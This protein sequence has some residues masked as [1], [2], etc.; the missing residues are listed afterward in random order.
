MRQEHLSASL[1]FSE[2]G[3][4]GRFFDGPD[5]LG[6]LPDFVDDGAWLRVA[7]GLAV[8]RKGCSSVG[9]S[10]RTGKGERPSG[11]AASHKS[12]DGKELRG[13]HPLTS[14][15]HWTTNERPWDDGI[16]VGEAILTGLSK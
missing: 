2:V 4:S 15:E 13:K 7:F 8:G 14:K 9:P 10:R 12:L 6:D 5:G 16:T 11:R 3:G 1:D